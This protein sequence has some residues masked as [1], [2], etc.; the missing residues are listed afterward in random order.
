MSCG[1]SRDS[2]SAAAT[3]TLSD[4]SR[5]ASGIVTLTSS[6]A[7]VAGESPG[8]LGAEREDDRS[9]AALP[10]SELG[11]PERAG[12]R[13]EADPARA[14][15]GAAGKRSAVAAGSAWTATGTRRRL[16]AEARSARG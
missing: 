1:A 5:P 14:C 2:T 3:V 11:E 12:V 6:C 8:A 15:A 16:P 10:R 9:G 13:L 4:S 7:R